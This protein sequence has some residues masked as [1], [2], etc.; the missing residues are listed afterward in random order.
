MAKKLKS[1]MGRAMAGIKELQG[2][3]VASAQNATTQTMKPDLHEQKRLR[4]LGEVVNGHIESLVVHEVDPARCRM[5]PHHNRIYNLLDENYCQDL[6]ASIKSQ[7][8]IEPAIARRLKDDPQ[9]DYEIIAGARRHWVASFLK[10]PLKIEIV[11]YDDEE[12]FLIS[13]ASNQYT[14]ISDFERAVEYVDALNTYYAG[15]Q[16]NMADR[17]NIAKT[18]LH[19][20]ISLGELPRE[21]V[22]VFPDPREISMNGALKL[23]SLIKSNKTTR[24]KIFNKADEIAGWPADKRSSSTAKEIQ[25]LLLQA[26]QETRGRKKTAA[27]ILYGEGGIALGEVMKG[28]AGSLTIKLNAGAHKDKPA[29]IKALTEFVNTAI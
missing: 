6:I 10:K 17:L 23:Q 18:T 3:K 27:T 9:F 13:N 19:R 12:A 1:T 11:N 4:S 25:R 22:R 16:S 14:D 28:R 20:Y 15:N 7:G 2:T 5:W 21:I 26:V 8:Q 29:L 24:E